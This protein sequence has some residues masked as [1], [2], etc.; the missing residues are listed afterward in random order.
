M[1]NAGNLSDI[2][3]K[4]TKKCYLI[5]G[6][7]VCTSKAILRKLQLIYRCG[8][9]ATEREQ[10]RLA[11]L[12]DDSELT[13]V[14]PTTNKHTIS[15]ERRVLFPYRLLPYAIIIN[16]NDGDRERTG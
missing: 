14:E 10:C 7:L 13:S 8:C 4:D 1:K 5:C 3:K 16:G 15:Q 9:C 6:H 11:R 2:K 12:N